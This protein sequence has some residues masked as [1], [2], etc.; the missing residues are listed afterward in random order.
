MST[1]ERDLLWREL[2]VDVE[3]RRATYRGNPIEISPN[4]PFPFRMLECLRNAFPS[5]V[6]K[7]ILIEHVWEN[8]GTESY[9]KLR[10]ALQIVLRPHGI[11][12]KMPDR[13]GMSIAVLNQSK[14]SAVQ[15]NP[16]GNADYLS[17]VVAYKTWEPSK[18]ILSRAEHSITVVDGFF[19]EHWD[20]DLCV[21]EATQKKQ[22]E[23]RPDSD[24]EKLAISVYMTSPE[25]DFGVQRGKEIE[26]PA[27]DK[28][29][30]IDILKKPISDDEREG[31]RTDFK[32]Y[33]KGLRLI[34]KSH[35]VE[36]NI[37]EYFAMPSTRMIVIDDKHFF[38]GWFPLWEHNP[39][40]FCMYL[41]DNSLQG[42]DLEVVKKLRGQIDNFISISKLVFSSSP[43]R[44][45]TK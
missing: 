21:A 43:A 22:N 38:F 6:S 45:K 4:T 11:V 18:K 27:E 15:S 13:L 39:G 16:T 37:Y 9:Y 14:S 32:G 33:I 20:L 35:P 19:S 42:A 30:C 1:S 24:K 41:E 36:L 5:L 10:E 2:V 31:Y 23:S 25:T 3:N 7:D 26:R 28:A 8:E 29:T 40:Y 34:S 44:G 12:L 17:K